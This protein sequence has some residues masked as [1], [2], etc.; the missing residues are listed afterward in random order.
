MSEVYS[1]LKMFHFSD[2]LRSLEQ[3]KIPFPVH[4]R[5]KP[6]NVCNHNCWFCAYRKDNL[7]LGE[8]MK[9]RDTLPVEKM[10]ELVEDFSVMKVKAVTL[11]GGGEPLIYSHVEEFLERLHMAGIKI[12]IL[13]NGSRL[14]G[15]LAERISQ[16]VTWVRISMDGWDGVSY[17]RSRST[18]EKEFDRIFANISAFLERRGPCLLSVSYIVDAENVFRLYEVCARLKNAGVSVVKLSPVIVDTDRERQNQYHDVIRA[19]AREQIE[20]IRENLCGPGFK[21]ADHY[22]RENESFQKNYHS[23][24]FAK[25]LTVVGADQ[26]IYSCQDKAYTD[27]GYL[28][29]WKERRFIEAWS[30]SEVQDR[31]R[32]IDPNRHC[33]HHCVAHR[34]NLILEDY[35][36]SDPGHI[37]FI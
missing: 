23:C 15:D 28:G 6:T 30:S 26:N 36:S 14:S 12:G 1:Q 22:H 11:S 9:V 37:D 24:H 20:K 8:N 17:A 35:L 16:W 29:S 21:I 34:K 7:E 31:L 2:R 27:G 4:V 13:T 19:T 5:V 32:G 10:R 25:L 3:G 33:R 18:S